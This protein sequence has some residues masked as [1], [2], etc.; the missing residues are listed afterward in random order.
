MDQIEGIT[1]SG[2]IPQ[3]FEGVSKEAPLTTSIF[4]WR[5]EKLLFFN[6]PPFGEVGQ[7]ASSANITQTSN[8]NVKLNS[9]PDS[10][11]GRNPLI[12][13]LSRQKH[14]DLNQSLS[15][16]A[17]NDQLNE[18]SKQIHFPELKVTDMDDGTEVSPLECGTFKHFPV[19]ITAV[20]VES[21]KPFV[22]PREIEVRLKEPIQVP[23]KVAKRV[24]QAP[25]DIP[26]WL[27][28]EHNPSPAYRSFQ[29]E[30]EWE[31]VIDPHDAWLQEDS[32]PAP[33]ATP[34]RR[35]RF[36]ASPFNRR[37]SRRASAPEQ[38]APLSIEIGDRDGIIL[39]GEVQPQG[40]GMV[41]LD[42]IP[43]PMPAPRNSSPTPDVQHE[44]HRKRQNQSRYHRARFFSKQE[45]CPELSF[46]CNSPTATA[47]II[48][49]QKN[50]A[51]DEDFKVHHYHTSPTSSPAR[52]FPIHHGNNKKMPVGDGVY[53][54]G[55]LTLTNDMRVRSISTTSTGQSTSF[56][57][58]PTDGSECES[59][60]SNG[61]NN[62]NNNNPLTFHPR[63]K[64][65]PETLEPLITA[66]DNVIL[67]PS[68]T[69]SSTKSASRRSL[70]GRVSSPIMM[71][72]KSTILAASKSTS[73]LK[74]VDLQ[75][76][77]RG[78]LA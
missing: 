37:Q 13:S 7:P 15:N 48:N 36:L 4:D 10:V 73:L 6:L 52:S 62:K 16:N 31:P 46:Q 24:Y 40:V 77:S 14:S 19:P 1:S 64:V 27:Q 43:R 18:M 22:P 8:P 55:G 59:F 45:S 54:S 28:I 25:L 49:K 34:S 12:P 70:W 67:S 3:T 44:Y 56:Q 39:R 30:N 23:H 50:V 68:T 76:L 35:P 32:I 41:D 69:A 75:R 26:K 61:E 21:D 2:G 53:R 9:Q 72:K 71:K 63:L 42:S 51:P 66:M 47:A 78:C 11:V 74:N 65:V 29:P 58:M 5:P 60:S 38:T 33:P 57:T 20:D 17:T